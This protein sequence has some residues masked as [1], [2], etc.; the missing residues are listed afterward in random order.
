MTRK[1]DHRPDKPRRKKASGFTRR[2]F[3]KTGAA[4]GLGAGALLGPERADAQGAST[5]PDGA[6]W[7]YEV[8]VVVAGAGCAGLTAAIRAR[9][10]GAS[11]LVVDS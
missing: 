8:D 1:D 10:L 7:D 2:D 5:T 11:V 9:D 4:A 3:V 6:A